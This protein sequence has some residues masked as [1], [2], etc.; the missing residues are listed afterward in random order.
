ML[1]EIRRAKEIAGTAD[2]AGVS[3]AGVVDTQRLLAV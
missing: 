2:G 3:V 1:V